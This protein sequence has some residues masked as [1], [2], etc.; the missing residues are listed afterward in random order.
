M[1]VVFTAAH[2]AGLM[3]L[4]RVQG[5]ADFTLN[6]AIRT[7]EIDSKNNFSL[8]WVRRNYRLKQSNRVE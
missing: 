3:L 4:H 1:V 8:G 6:V 7:L 5:F 2:W